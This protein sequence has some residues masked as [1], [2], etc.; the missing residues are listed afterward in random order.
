MSTK[1][2]VLPR[3][4]MVEGSSPSSGV[5]FFALLSHRALHFVMLYPLRA[6]PEFSAFGFT[7]FE[8]CATYKPQ[9]WCAYVVLTESPQ[10]PM[11]DVPQWR[12]A[13]ALK[14]AMTMT[15]RK[16][17]CLPRHHSHDAVVTM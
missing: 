6:T 4:R 13:T 11:T 12:R 2:Q 7:H 14:T 17:A 15:C 3:H 1:Q 8:R 9:R 5:A 10:P 16:I